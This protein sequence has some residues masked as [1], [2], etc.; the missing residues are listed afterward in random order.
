MEQ[1]PTLDLQAVLDQY[2]D[3]VRRCRYGSF[4]GVIKDG[5]IVVFAIEHEWRPQMETGRP[6]TE[7]ESPS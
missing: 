5:K 7:D 4:R 1:D 2:S 6:R 3:E